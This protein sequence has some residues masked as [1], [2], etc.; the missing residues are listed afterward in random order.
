MASSASASVAPATVSPASGTSPTAAPSLPALTLLWQKGGPTSSKPATWQPA[1]D[2]ATGNIW[3][4]ASFDDVFWIFSPDGKYLESWGTPGKG[5][6]Q[7]ALATRDE[8]PDPRGSITFTA[9]GGFYVVDTGNDRIERFD[10]NGHYLMQFGGFGHQDGKFTRPLD[11]ATDGKTV[12]V[13]DDDKLQVQAF[14]MN[15]TFLRT[16]P[17]TDYG[18]ITIDETGRLVTTTGGEV[19][20]TALAVLVI[21]PMTG[22]P[23]AKYPLP[24]IGR[25]LLG[26]AVDVAGDIFVNV[27]PNMDSAPHTMVGLVELDKTGKLM[28]TWSTAGETIAVAPDGKAVYLASDWPYI[29]K[30]ALPTP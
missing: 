28:G 5:D 20:P 23:V 15:G 1:I 6:G 16:L 17:W 11:I 4:A 26:G 22:Q 8:N 25:V 29:R 30:Y 7:L 2:P 13:S 24:P 19:E 21:D 27:A 18:M 9:D 14:D 3:V 10:K 12:Y